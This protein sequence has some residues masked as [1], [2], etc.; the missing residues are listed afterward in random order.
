MLALSGTLALSYTLSRVM[1][2][3]GPNFSSTVL[4]QYVYKMGME[5]GSYGY[6]MAITVFTTVLS[7]AL[8]VASRILTGRDEKEGGAK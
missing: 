6:A 2:G 4:L 3:G 7:V 1:T 8:S 5:K